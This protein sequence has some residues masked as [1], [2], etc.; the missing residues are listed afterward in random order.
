MNVKST[1]THT[2]SA[3]FKF[4]LYWT[5]VSRICEWSIKEGLCPEIVPAHTGEMNTEIL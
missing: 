4:L 3:L 2:F 1:V 5:I